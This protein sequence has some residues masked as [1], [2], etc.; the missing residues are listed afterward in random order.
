MFQSST[1]LLEV[2]GTSHLL[3]S[4]HG[5][6]EKTKGGVIRKSYQLLKRFPQDHHES[7]RMN[8]IKFFNTEL[9]FQ[10]GQ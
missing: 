1:E 7:L 2:N 9:E 5:F 3:H 6:E 8:S 4:I 10:K